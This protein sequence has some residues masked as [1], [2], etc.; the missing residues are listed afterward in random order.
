L[1]DGKPV[2]ALESTIIAH[3]MSFPRNLETAL[4]VEEI[5]RANGAEPCTIAVLGG[6]LRAGLDQDE[7]ERIARGG[8]AIMKCSTRELP[9][10]M[11]TGCDG[12]TTVASTARIAALCG[13]SVFATGGIGGVHREAQ[14]TFD[15]SAD[16]HELAESNVAVVSAGAKAILD[17]PLTLEMLETLAVPVVGYGT[18]RFPSFYSRDSG[19]PVPMRADT[20]D[21]VAAMMN[22][23]WSLGMK[24]GFLVANPIPVEFEI[25]RE[26]ISP[27]IEEAVQEAQRRGIR[28][29]DVTPFLLARLAEQTA[30]R[31]L[32]ANIALVKN[33][34][35][36]AARIAVAYARKL[37][38]E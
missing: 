26:E 31:S 21:E 17:L 5:V 4:E 15:V 27:A 38:N 14:Q 34:A 30:G 36:V 33:N 35:A 28:G 11:A 10:V 13:V 24:G 25:P 3:G 1:Y 16:L 29:K 6:R 9:F 8:A 32:A 7:V 20:A 37:K 2:V 12:A 22:A 23:K 18:D 19:L